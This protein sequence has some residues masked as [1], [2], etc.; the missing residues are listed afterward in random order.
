M[1]TV[2]LRRTAWA[3]ALVAAIVVATVLTVGRGGPT[4]VHA[5][6]A[7]SD[8][9][10]SVTGVGDADGAPD[11]LNADF[12]VHVTRDTVQSA[13][14]A[15]A[16]AARKVLAALAKSGVARKDTRTTNLSIDQHY[17]NHGTVVGYDASETIRARIHP[18]AQAGRTI[19]AAATAAGN[20]VAVDGLSFDIEDDD[21]LVTAARSAAYDDAKARAD[22]Y[23]QLSNRS[24]GRVI[25][26]KEQI[27]RPDPQPYYYGDAVR[28]A[29][30]E[31]KSV[32]IRGGQQ[33]LTVHVSV[34]WQLS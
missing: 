31:A 12:R 19:S 21:A 20:D 24:L 14:D 27:D 9:T 16:A 7:T 15:Q 4:P 11:T 22:Q 32:P 33:T 8:D 34:V 28:A 18:L 6:D 10:V 13:L 23:A 26:I 5:A 2:T 17:D 25:S 1:P 3:T 29:P 30:L